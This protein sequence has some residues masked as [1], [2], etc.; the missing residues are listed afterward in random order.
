MENCTM[1]IPELKKK[2]TNTK[3]KKLMIGEI[4]EKKISSV[5][6]LYLDTQG[7]QQLLDI[8]G[9]NLFFSVDEHLTARIRFNVEKVFTDIQKKNIDKETLKTSYVFNLMAPYN[10]WFPVQN[11]QKIDWE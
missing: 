7:R 1:V 11:L 3:G 8:E 10:I 2:F 6:V 4:L 5:Q 9:V